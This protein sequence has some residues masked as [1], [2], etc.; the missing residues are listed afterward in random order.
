MRQECDHAARKTLGAKATVLECGQLTHSGVLETLAVIKLKG[1][2]DTELGVPVS[3]FV[4]LRKDNL[5]WKMELMAD[6]M[7]VR[8]GAGYVGVYNIDDSADA[9][10][11]R[12]DIS[13]GGSDA[14]NTLFIMLRYIDP[15]GETEA[16]PVG[17]G[18]NPVVQRFQ[19]YSENGTPLEEIKNPKHFRS[20]VR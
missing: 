13:G 1:F 2:K 9:D 18:W 3:S 6:R 7:P 4:I 10:R 17:I 12:I 8:N 20:K 11:Y 16:W 14:K 5:E 19:E 15:D